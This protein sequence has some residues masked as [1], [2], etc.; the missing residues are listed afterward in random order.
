L[1]VSRKMSP[2]TWRDSPF[3]AIIHPEGSFPVIADRLTRYG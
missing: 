1:T 3:Q 2:A